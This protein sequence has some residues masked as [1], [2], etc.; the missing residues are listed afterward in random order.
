MNALEA[1]IDRKL[2]KL[3]E[4]QQLILS[5]HEKLVA[6][7]N[8]IASKREE[9]ALLKQKQVL[10][11][12]PAA[13]PVA[14]PEVQQLQ[15]V[16][17]N[18]VLAIQSIPS[19]SLETRTH[20]DAV[21]APVLPPPILPATGTSGSVLPATPNNKRGLSLLGLAS[22]AD[23][24]EMDDSE[25][26][27]FSPVRNT[28]Q[29]TAPYPSPTT[30][31]TDPYEGANALS[32]PAQVALNKDA[33]EAVMS[34]LPSIATPARAG[35]SATTPSAEASSFSHMTASL[36]LRPCSKKNWIS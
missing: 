11:I 2:T 19:L 8:D 14:Q 26:D 32:V 12:A 28:Q 1:Y 7:Q 21:L 22:G 9:L 20:L 23:V 6:T 27:S 33:V 36:S 29:R 13:I 16:L 5:S 35:A 18:V 24:T 25:R 10:A 34:R 15:S 31:E 17:S 4:F 30:V 3:L